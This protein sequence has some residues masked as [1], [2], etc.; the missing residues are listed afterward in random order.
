MQS[1]LVGF[2]SLELRYH[3]TLNIR[4]GFG[5]LVQ[6]V[7]KSE[8][9]SLSRVHGKAYKNDF[10]HVKFLSKFLATEKYILTKL[11]VQKNKVDKQKKLGSKNFHKY[12]QLQ[13]ANRSNKAKQ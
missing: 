3:L 5:F 11:D 1:S 8:G 13:I 9:Q 10:V 12:L 4:E 7:Q 6:H 2:E